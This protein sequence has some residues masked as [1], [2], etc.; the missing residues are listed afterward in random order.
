[1]CLFVY[2]TQSKNINNEILSTF[3][4]LILSSALI[5]RVRIIIFWGSAVNRVKISFSELFPTQVHNIDVKLVLQ[6]T[7]HPRANH[8]ALLMIQFMFHLITVT[9]WFLFFTFTLNFNQVPFVPRMSMNALWT[10]FSIGISRDHEKLK[11]MFDRR[12]RWDQTNTI[13]YNRWN[14]FNSKHIRQ[15]KKELDSKSEKRF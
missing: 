15:M 5:G 3:W 9:T 12:D 4:V 2:W 10:N 7:P 14:A 13:S 1:M 11:K 8:C 6:E